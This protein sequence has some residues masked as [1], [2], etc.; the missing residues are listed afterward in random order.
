[1]ADISFNHGVRVF[2]S[3]DNPL[4]IR[5]S[6]S[7]VLAHI[8]T[9]PD[10]D[11]D[12]FPMHT[13]VLLKG[14]E[15]AGKIRKL[16]TTGELRRIVDGVLDQE[17]TYQ[18]II[19]IPHS[20]DQNDQISHFVGN[21][22]DRTG[23]HALEKIYGMPEYNRRHRPK[24]VTVPGRTAGAFTPVAQEL[25][26]I[27]TKMRAVA[28]VDGPN[29]TDE[30][31]VAWRNEFT[32]DRLYPIDPYVKV[33]DD[34]ANAYRHEP[35]SPRFAGV[36]ARVDRTSGFWWSVSNKPIYGIS[37]IA[38]PMNYGLQSNYLNE[39]GVNTIIPGDDGGWTTWG[40]RMATGAAFKLF[41]PVRRTTD[42]INEAI[43]KEYR[44]F[45]DAPMTAVQCKLMLESGNAFMRALAAEGAI[46]N[47]HMF[48]DRER[49]LD[50]ELGQGRVTLG[51]KFLPP[52][53]EDIRII[54]YYE[55][56]YFAV[57]R[58]QVLNEN[59]LSFSAIAA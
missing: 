26:G 27:L 42:I 36:Q 34:V 56:T 30:A 14:S 24:I 28:F 8:A 40:N 44:R 35:A 41:L 6:Q 19:R 50:S 2:E 3:D 48:W 54:Q 9:A 43:E 58:D 23:V 21:S 15:D 4:L 22:A 17:G 31:A 1:M 20:A 49:N 16:G 45:N 39:N 11:N 57:L 13:P 7:A 55:I 53:M 59:N 33:W 32:S 37:G 52:P 25:P 12:T 47:G 46:Y 5:T 10:A 18:Y 38:R 51:V 29:T